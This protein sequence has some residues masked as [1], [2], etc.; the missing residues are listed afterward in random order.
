M[1]PAS[2]WE[3][4]NSRAREMH[5][6]ALMHLLLKQAALIPTEMYHMYLYFTAYNVL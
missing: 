1:S 6:D 3:D 4:Q 5:G 2:R